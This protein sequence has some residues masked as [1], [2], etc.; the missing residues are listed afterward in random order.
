MGENR[1]ATEATPTAVADRIRLLTLALV[2]AV[3]LASA[4]ARGSEPTN[5]PPEGPNVDSTSPLP[6]GPEG[7][8]VTVDLG[9]V[10]L[11]T[12]SPV[13]I[14]GFENST[15]LYVRATNTGTD[16]VTV[17]RPTPIEVDFSIPEGG[18]PPRHFYA[19]GL[20]HV[21]IEPGATATFEFMTTRGSPEL[22]VSLPFSLEGGEPSTVLTIPIHSVDGEHGYPV[23]ELHEMP[24][25]ATI[26]GRVS[27]PAGEPITGIEVFVFALGNTALDPWR[28]DVGRDGTFVIDVPSTDDLRAALGDRPLPY[29][30]VGFSIDVRAEAHTAGHAEVTQLARGA[31]ATVDLEIERVTPVD[32]ELVGELSTGGVYGYW[33]ALPLPRFETIVAV[34]ARHPPM[35][36]QPGHVVAVDLAGSELWRFEVPNEC[37]GLDVSIAGD[38]AVACHDGGVFLLDSNGALRWERTFDQMNRLARFSPD[39]TTVIAGPDGNSDI[40]LLDARSGENVWAFDPEERLDWLRNARWSPDGSRFVTSHADGRL[41]VFSDDFDLLWEV[42]IGEFAML[43]EV[44]ADH[45][46]YAAGKNRELFGFDGEGNLRFRRRIPNHVVTAGSNN[47]DASGN[48]IALGTVGGVLQMYDTDGTMRWQRRFEGDLQGHNALDMTPDGSLVVV[49]GAG[50]VGNAGVVSLFERDG[51]LLWQ[52]MHPDGRDQG[53][54]PAPYEYDHNQRGVITVAIS[55]DGRRIVA[56]YGDSTIRIFERVG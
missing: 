21:R 51:G 3:I 43:L 31:T 10:T 15:N 1:T 44:D 8:I 42:D 2:V 28:T 13:T 53:T 56:G 16:A 38:T 46:V 55:D 5:A 4:C 35:L 39:G 54:M 9:P 32:F 22:E 52:E 33:W 34:Q 45:N 24:R 11:E 30:A 23:R 6:E 29:E 19:L 49:G 47:M 7:G 26:R 20:P 27:T 40:V 48:W 18:N 36:D 12:Y 41:A 17:R 37:W 25:T 50:S 14:T